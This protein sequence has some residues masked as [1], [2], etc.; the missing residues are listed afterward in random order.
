M[1][2]M[3]LL[4]CAHN[5]LLAIHRRIATERSLVSVLSPLR[6]RVRP[7]CGC[8]RVPVTLTAH[9]DFTSSSPSSINSYCVTFNCRSTKQCKSFKYYVP[10][11]SFSNTNDNDDLTIHGRAIRVSKAGTNSEFNTLNIE[12]DP[13][14]KSLLKDIATDFVVAEENTSNN[15]LDRSED[16]SSSSS[17]SDSDS[18]SSSESDSDSSSSSESDSDSS[19]SSESDSSDSEAECDDNSPQR[20]GVVTPAEV[21]AEL[22]KYDYE[23][24]DDDIVL[25]E[26][27][28]VEERVL[29]ISTESM[30]YS[31]LVSGLAMS[32]IMC[33]LYKQSPI[34]LFVDDYK[35]ISHQNLSYNSFKF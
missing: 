26:E 1:H 2:N 7:Y 24:F 5:A 23:E 13:D 22:L 11:R 10:H 18:S 31:A 20:R 35:E 9:T 32:T 8:G 6:S 15:S 28:I 4:H 34:K 14:T 27:N 16:D 33:N 17:E 12:N 25:E 21:D 3:T 29:P 30:L 19:S